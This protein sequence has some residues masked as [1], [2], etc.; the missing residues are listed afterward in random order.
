MVKFSIC[1]AV[2]KIFL[3]P[4]WVFLGR[5]CRLW[6]CPADKQGGGGG[7]M[8]ST[9]YGG[10]STEDWATPPPAPFLS[11]SPVL[12][13]SLSL[14]CSYI[15]LCGRTVHVLPISMIDKLAIQFLKAQT[16]QKILPKFFAKST[17]G[18][19]KIS[20]GV[21]LPFAQLAR[22][23]SH[24]CL[25]WVWHQILDFRFF[26]ESVFPWHWVYNRGHFKFLCKFTEI[27]ESK[28]LSPVSMTRA[29]IKKIFEIKSFSYFWEMLLGCCFQSHNDFLL[30]VHFEV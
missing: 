24:N 27:F 4:F 6:A 30:N 23:T 1:S 17:S 12:C 21:Q 16:I 9:W 29:I 7:L 13:T 20:W 25:K 14:F 18:Y 22:H 8:V 11:L 2:C 5:L 15:D 3:S 19:A 10:Y 28:G 26:H